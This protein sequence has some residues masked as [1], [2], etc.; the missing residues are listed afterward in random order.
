MPQYRSQVIYVHQRPA[1]FSGTVA[2]NLAL[3]RQLSSNRP[4]F[5]APTVIMDRLETWITALGR[6]ADFLARPADSLSGGGLQILA[7]LRAAQLDPVVL[8]LDEP[9]ASLDAATGQ[10]LESLLQDWL[11]AATGRAAILVS[12]DET[13]LQRLITAVYTLTATH[14]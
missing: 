10:R 11:G 8:L 5:S 7:W 1:V 12:H 9:N 4:Q 6:P 13:Q 2:E 3:V 14:D